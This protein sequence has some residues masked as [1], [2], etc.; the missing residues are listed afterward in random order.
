MKIPE[1]ARSLAKTVLP[2]AA[3]LVLQILVIAVLAG[4]FTEKIQ[5]GET[6][7]G[8]L[9][10]VGQDAGREVLRVGYGDF[11]R[12]RLPAERGRV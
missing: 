12:T 8:A 1:V 6:A 10:G 7:V 5:P 4:V 2:I 3:G 11:L 9:P